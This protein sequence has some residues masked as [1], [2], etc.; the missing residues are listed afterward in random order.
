MPKCLRPL[1][2]EEEFS[3]LPPHR[4]QRWWRDFN[5]PMRKWLHRGKAVQNLPWG[6]G[7]LTPGTMPGPPVV[8]E[9]ASLRQCRIS[10]HSPMAIQ[11]PAPFGV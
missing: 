2:L 10:I 8:G 1:T 9:G 7:P 5:H 6:E 4:F 3:P 11:D